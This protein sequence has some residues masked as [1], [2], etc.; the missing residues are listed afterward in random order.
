MVTT[1]SDPNYPP[2][3]SYPSGYN[4]PQQ[5]T[6]NLFSILAIVFGIVAV[7]FLPIVFGLAAIVLGIIARSK[8]ERLSTIGLVVAILGTL[9]G[10]VIGYL[11]Y[12]SMA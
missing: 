9:A 11:V 1:M 2:P 6:S 10:F 5:N 7:L 12:R 8:G 3:P 4:A